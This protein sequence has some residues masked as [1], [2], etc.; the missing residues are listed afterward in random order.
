MY[1]LILTFYVA[2]IRVMVTSTTQSYV[3]ND[4]RLRPENNQSKDKN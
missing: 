2:E 1:T 4:V 3:R